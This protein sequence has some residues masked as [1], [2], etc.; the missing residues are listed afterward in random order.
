MKIAVITSGILPVPAVQGGAVENLIDFYLEY[1]DIHQLH[2]ITVF[3]VYHPDVKTHPALL[4]T[5]N[6][7]IY[8]NTNSIW[9]KIRAKLYYNFSKKDYYDPYIDSFFEIIC[10]KLKKQNIDLFVLEN[11]PKFSIELNKR[12]PA[13]P[14]ISHIHTNLL[15]KKDEL[16]KNIIRYSNR[17][18]TVSNFIKK[19]IL[20]I[21][22]PAKVSTV[23]NGID[24]KLFNPN[25]KPADRKLLGFLENDF[26]VVFTGR[27]IPE[28]GIKELLQAIILLKNQKDIKLLI[29]GAEN[30]ADSPNNSTFVYELKQLSSELS[31]KIVF[32]GFVP[33]KEI[34]K[35]LAIANVMVVPSNINEAFGMTC[36]EACAMGLPVIAT[37]DGGIP[38]TLVGQKHIMIDKQGNLPKQISDAIVKIRNN[39]EL[40]TGNFLPKQFTKGNYAKCLFSTLSNQIS[41]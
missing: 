33:Y 5:S 21:G 39:Y 30:F 38:E 12:F 23:Y 34:P 29:I 4:S 1:N 6:H 24:S 16:T 10:K 27:L 15:Y 18:I 2:D 19:E 25:T 11:R 3:S 14:I 32:T 26:I 31:G 17:F 40:Y 41:L 22:I 7:Y 37:N 20:N 35:F 8:I 36:I 28:K 9:F 13:I